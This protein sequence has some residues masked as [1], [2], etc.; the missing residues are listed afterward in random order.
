MCRVPPGLAIGAN[1]R[2]PVHWR[3]PKL[4]ARVSHGPQPDR[5]DRPLTSDMHCSS[6][7]TRLPPER[8]CARLRDRRSHEN[9]RS[10][11]LDNYST[12][13]MPASWLRRRRPGRQGLSVVAG[14]V[15]VVRAS[16]FTCPPGQFQ[17]RTR[18]TSIT[19]CAPQPI[20]KSLVIPRKPTEYGDGH[21]VGAVRIGVSS[22][23]R[24]TR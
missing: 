19:R 10:T 14:L 1:L 9:T 4:N 13:L 8:P 20:S 5:R 3:T 24:R 16:R 23:S 6:Q 22:G 21:N 15:F 2:P 17:R 11:G 12:G 18:N 7:R